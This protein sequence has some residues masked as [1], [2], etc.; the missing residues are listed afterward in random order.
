MGAG[1]GSLAAFALKGGMK[2]MG[3]A[4][5]ITCVIGAKMGN[6]YEHERR[7]LFINRK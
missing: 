1:V 6:Y 7:S 5:F 3:L 4:G 2:Q